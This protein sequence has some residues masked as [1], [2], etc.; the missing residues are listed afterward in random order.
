MNRESITVELSGTRHEVQIVKVGTV[1]SRE[2]VVNPVD[3]T[4][5]VYTSA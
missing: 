2:S 3:A 1:V 4:S 5:R